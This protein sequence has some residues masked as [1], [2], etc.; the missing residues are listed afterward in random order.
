M[1]SP[2]INISVVYL[3]GLFSDETLRVNTWNFKSCGI[4]G[5]VEGLVYFSY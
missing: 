3:K 1:K 5:T 2:G 4:N